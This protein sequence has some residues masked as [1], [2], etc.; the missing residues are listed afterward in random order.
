M[1]SDETQPS[2]NSCAALDWARHLVS[3][4]R[5]YYLPCGW[6]LCYRCLSSH[7]EIEIWSEYL[8]L[9]IDRGI[10]S[11]IH[12]LIVCI[13]SEVHGREHDKQ[14]RPVHLWKGCNM[15]IITRAKRQ[16]YYATNF[17]ERTADSP[18]PIPVPGYAELGHGRNCCLIS[19]LR[20][21]ALQLS[22]VNHIR[23]HKMYGFRSLCASA[24]EILRSWMD[25]FKTIPMPQDYA[26][27]CC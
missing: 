15:L 4:K 18:V 10:G 27:H 14:H 2:G 12:K 17:T 22:R 5:V 9:Y 19:F 24:R 26:P 21:A 8:I 23:R 11:L 13:C 16:R 7:Y 3:W 1:I 6:I 20:S 25:R